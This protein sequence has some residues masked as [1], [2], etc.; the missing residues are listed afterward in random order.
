MAGSAVN[1]SANEVKNCITGDGVRRFSSAWLRHQLVDPRLEMRHGVEFIPSS[2][3]LPGGG[4]RD[5]RDEARGH[6][7]R[8]MVGEY[9]RPCSFT[10]AV[11]HRGIVRQL[12][13]RALNLGR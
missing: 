6:G 8:R 3:A 5:C 13:H 9:V 4:G 12:L 11:A 7:V 2:R 1:M 10:D